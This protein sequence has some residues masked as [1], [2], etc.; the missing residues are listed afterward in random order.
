MSATATAPAVCEEQVAVRRQR[1]PCTGPGGVTLGQLLARAR[2]AADAGAVTGCPVCGGAMQAHGLEAQC[3][4]C[5]T[6]LS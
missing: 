5:G 3:G 1:R 4:S 2:E 6:R